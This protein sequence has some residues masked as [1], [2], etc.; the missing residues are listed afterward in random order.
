VQLADELGQAGVVLAAR[1]QVAVEVGEPQGVGAV[2][3]AARL[4]VDDYESARHARSVVSW[5][6]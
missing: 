1:H 5:C 6:W 3:E 2:V 4:A